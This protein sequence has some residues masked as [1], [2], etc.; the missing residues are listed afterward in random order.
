[1]VSCD[2]E[3]DPWWNDSQEPDARCSDPVCEECTPAI[4]PAPIIAI[5]N[6]PV[7]HVTHVVAGFTY[8]EVIRSGE[9]VDFYESGDWS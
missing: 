3:S 9:L 7:T 5:P 1:M 4:K 8:V 2:A 6:V